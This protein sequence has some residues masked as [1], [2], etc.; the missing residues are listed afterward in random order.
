M[1]DTRKE[2]E[3]FC[4][5]LRDNKQIL[6]ELKNEIAQL[7]YD[8]LDEDDINRHIISTAKENGFNFTYEDLKDYEKEMQ[9]GKELSDEQ[10]LEIVGG[11]SIRK[12]IAGG[13]LSLI[14]FISPS[15]MLANNMHA[16]AASNNTY[17]TCV[18]VEKTDNEDQIDLNSY[19]KEAKI[20]EAQEKAFEIT[21]KLF[22]KTL[23]NVAQLH[24]IS[25]YRYYK[26]FPE[27]ELEKQLDSAVENGDLPIKEFT[28]GQINS[29][30][31]L[32]EE[33][34]NG[35]SP[36]FKIIKGIDALKLSETADDCSIVQVA[37]Q[38]NALESVSTQPSAVKEWIYDNTQGPRASLQSVAAAKHR[39]AAHLQNELPDAIQGVLEKC[40]LKDGNN[41]LKK[42]PGLYKNGY[43]QLLK[44]DSIEDLQS[45][46]DFLIS[47]INEFKVLSQWVK[48]EGT[49]KKQLQVF[50]AAPSFQG[51]YVDWNKNDNKTK[52]LKEICDVIVSNEY[53]SI[54]QI[55][56]IRSEQIGEPVSLHLTLIGQ[57]VFQNPP[58]IIKSSIEKVKQ[59]LKG[60]NVKFY[61]HGWSEKDCQKWEKYM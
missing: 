45:L 9:K 13:L 33:K 48:C 12:S 46:K 10:L 31:K 4:L 30:A 57:G 27:T 3:G 22:S 17:V 36:E 42:Y 52:L 15:S 35:K 19:L 8:L 28:L 56:A 18:N 50:S 51:A 7:K 43:L 37:S 34:E 49:G 6:K 59:E 20:S 11:S 60:T 5:F 58:E 55:A 23:S 41:I 21:N 53:K 61:L 40:I 38:F 39:E 54:A 44:I 47:N 25:S 29:E 1:K 24:E 14:T 32:N 16:Y 26:I 2:I